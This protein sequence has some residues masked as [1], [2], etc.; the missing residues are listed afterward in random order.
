VSW[1]M[2]QFLSENIIINADESLWIFR[3]MWSNVMLID[4]IRNSVYNEKT[5]L[6]E[7][8][9]QKWPISFYWK[10]HTVSLI[11]RRIDIF[12][13]NVTYITVNL[14]LYLSLSWVFQS[15]TSYG[16]SL[17]AYTLKKTSNAPFIILSISSMIIIWATWNLQYI[18]FKAFK[19][20]FLI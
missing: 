4:V 17:L 15:I 8:Y 11:G 5:Q 13:S 1:N 3:N 18:K 7:G 19:G 16:L 20:I 14:C 6:I 10:A 12:W 2:S 9:K